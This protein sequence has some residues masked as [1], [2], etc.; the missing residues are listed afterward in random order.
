MKLLLCDDH[1]LL[2]ETLQ[3]L[4][5]SAGHEVLVAHQ[6]DAALDL[7]E[8]ERPDVCVMDIGFPDG[9]GL[10]ALSRVADRSPQ[11]R[12]LMLS[13]SRTTDLVRSAIDLGA[14]GYLCKDVGAA[15]IVHAVE[16]ILEGDIVLDPEVVRVLARRTRPRPDDI[17]WL[18]GFLTGREREV[19]RRIILGQGTQEMADEMHVSRSTARTHVQNA[20]RKL[21]VHSR[22]EA[23]AAVSRRKGDG[24]PVDG[25]V[26]FQRTGRHTGHGN[27]SIG[28]ATSPRLR[29]PQ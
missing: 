2:A 23:V 28:N 16:R 18:M 10:D 14:R 21:G 17:E 7:L 27:G 4:L 8:E 25:G 19:L 20:L 15:T 12:V 24:Q 26:P 29:H 3:T 5:V 6:P 13:A 1:V 22:L 9:N 11:T